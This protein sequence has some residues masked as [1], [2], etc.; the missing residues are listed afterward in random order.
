M[1]RPP[2][3]QPLDEMVYRGVSAPGFQRMFLDGLA[4]Q[5][6]PGT[7]GPPRVHAGAQGH[8]VDDPGVPPVQPSNERPSLPQAPETRDLL[9]RHLKRNIMRLAKR[10]YGNQ[11]LPL[12]RD[13]RTARPIPRGHKPEETQ[14]LRHDGARLTDRTAARRQDLHPPARNQVQR[15]PLTEARRSGVTAA[16]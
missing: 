9:V 4:Q 5:V 12:A 11:I 2:L 7:G 13:H 8:A 3:G 14:K 16:A 1:S 10:P 6:V 15:R